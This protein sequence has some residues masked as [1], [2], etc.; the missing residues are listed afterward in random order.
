MYESILALADYLKGKA[1]YPPARKV[2]N[3]LFN[4]SISSFF[5]ERFY[6]HYQ[7][8]N[9]QDYK[10]ILDFFVKG[11]FFIPFTIFF[12]VY[13]STQL[14]GIILFSLLTYFKSIKITRLLLYYQIKKGTIDD[15]IKSI[16]RLSTKVAP[17]R[18]TKAFVLSMYQN[19]RHQ[20]T[21]EAFTVLE[22][23]LTPAKQNLE[24]SFYFSFRALIAITVYYSSLP[25]FSLM[26]YIVALVTL[27]GAMYLILL[28]Y[29][30]LDILPTLAR[31]MH[32]EAE[33]YL[34]SYLQ[35]SQKRQTE[36]V[37]D[38]ISEN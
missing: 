34:N 27:C 3:L 26:L 13:L 28:A 35:E 14:L 19:L 33:R 25:Q 38:K 16:T 24:F 6:G 21:P 7:W 31:R 20:I 36:Q 10:G 4:I 12:T 29:R 9:Y 2:L 5:Y 23:E 32:V 18:I 22:T 15:G 8:L 11:K 37:T 1:I 17:V 30:C